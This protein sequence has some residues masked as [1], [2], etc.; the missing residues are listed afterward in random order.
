MQPAIKGSSGI[1]PGIQRHPT[2]SYRREVHHAEQIYRRGS[3]KR[4]A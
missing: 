1:L 4:F 2:F 3:K